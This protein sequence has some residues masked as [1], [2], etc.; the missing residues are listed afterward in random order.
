[1]K[2]NSNPAHATASPAAPATRSDTASLPSGA[3]QSS[4]SAKVALSSTSRTLLALQNGETDI[5]VAKVA[6]IRE[7]IA[8]GDI[9]IDTGKIADGLLAS[10]QELLR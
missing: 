3:A 10:A 8:R 4:S 9:K 1:M 6:A 5:D 7:A 2:V